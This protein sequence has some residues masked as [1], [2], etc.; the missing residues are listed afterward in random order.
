MKTD[1]T[2]VT[3]TRRPMNSLEVTLDY[4]RTGLTVKLPA[5]RV[6]GPLAIRDVP[7]LADPAGAVAEALER[8]IGAAPL[9]ELAAGP[10]KR[11]HPRVRHHPA[12]AEPDDPRPRPPRAPRCG[13]RPG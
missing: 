6:V 10:G 12:R 5:D 8:P 9:R 3:P 1:R 7:P 11:L 4:G 13:H 2:D